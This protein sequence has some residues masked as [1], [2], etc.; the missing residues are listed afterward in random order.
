MDPAIQIRDGNDEETILQYMEVLDQLPPIDVF[1][2]LGGLYVADGFHRLAA[3]IRSGRRTI[4][5]NIHQGTYDEAAVFAATANARNG[6]RLTKDERDRGIR[7]LKQ[8]HDDWS[9]ERISQEMGVSRS[10]VTNLLRVDEYRRS[11]HTEAVRQLPDASIVE[12]LNAKE[13]DRQPLTEA[14]V[15]RGWGRDATRQAVRNLEDDR[16]PEEHKERLR[17][18]E[19]DPVIFSSEGKAVA[20]TP[21]IVGRRVKE[22][23]AN[24]A[25][26]ALDRALAQLARLRLFRPEVIASTAGDLRTQ[27]LIQELP[28]YIEF[29]EDVRAHL[30]GEK[31][32]LEL[33]P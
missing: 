26:L 9:H 25:V 24:D 16:V 30:T 17:A 15:D 20:V 2:T 10:T 19:A 23:E 8:I 12:V 28:G 14:A 3:A 33:V 27:R 1:E 22:L 21:D 18:G 7:R 6:Q 11:H 29:L 31:E 13:D 4:P 5:A 32:R